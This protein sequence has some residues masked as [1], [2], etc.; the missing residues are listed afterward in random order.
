MRNELIGFINAIALASAVV[1]GCSSSDSGGGS[2]GS[3]HSQG[4]SSAGGSAGSSNAAAGSNNTA[5][6]SGGAAAGSNN[7]AAGS[8][9]AAAGSSNAAAGSS[10]GGASGTGSV[11]SI[12]SSKPLSGLSA[13]EAKTL[14]DDTF[15]YFG[16]AIA[17]PITCKWKGLNKATSSSAPTQEVLT[18]TC[19]DE[20]SGCLTAAATT[21]NSGC[22]AIPTS[23]CSTTVAQYSTCIQDQVLAF[24]QTVNGLPSCATFMTSGT[25]AIYEA[26]G[27]NPPPSCVFDA[28]CPGLSPPNPLY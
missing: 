27:A 16:S 23:G 9:G 2:A 17:K 12:S 21:E 28:T 15:A 8:G 10:S 1:T 6:G 20:E 18:K 22:N 7:T 3:P 4:G 13:A 25:S 14:C 5:A 24:A 11:T 26:Q 19:T